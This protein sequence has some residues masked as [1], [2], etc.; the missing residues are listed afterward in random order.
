MTTVHYP[1]YN[2]TALFAGD[3]PA[4]SRVITIAAGANAAGTVLPRGTVLG[5]VT[6]TSSFVVATSAATD[7]SNH[8]ICILAGDVDASAGAVSCPAYYTG[9]F[10]DIELNVG[11]GLT[12]A[13]VDAYFASTGQ[14]IFIRAVGTVA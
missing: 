12:P 9:E 10:A 3:F 8:P 7:G 4:R 13:S 11:A 6:A 2:P 1:S 5:E 14:S